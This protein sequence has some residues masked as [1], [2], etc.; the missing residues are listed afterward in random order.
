MFKDV[1]NPKHDEMFKFAITVTALLF[2]AIT[3]AAS[4]EISSLI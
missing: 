1:Q 4:Y 3:L 2:V